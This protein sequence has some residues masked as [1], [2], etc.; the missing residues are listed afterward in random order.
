MNVAPLETSFSV[1]ADN[2]P[3]GLARPLVCRW[4]AQASTLGVVVFCHGLGSNGSEYAELSRHLAS[5]GYLMVHPTFDDAISLVAASEP[6]LGL[7]PTANLSHW[8]SLPEVRARMHQILLSPDSWLRRV[9]TVTAIMD[10]LPLVLSATCGSQ[11][12]PLPVA[13]AGHSF[14]AYTAQLLAGAEIDLPGDPG[15][16]FVDPRFAS[17]VFLSG[18]GRNQQGLRDGSWDRV[19]LPTLTITGTLDRGA[20]GGGWEWKSE[21]FTLASAPDQYLAVIEDGDHFLG[22]FDADHRRVV[23]AQ[24]AAVRQLTGQFLDSTLKQNSDSR[25]ALRATPGQIGDCRLTFHYR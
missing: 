7:D 16:R 19:A 21:P 15:R 4:P 5:R 14:G 9:A 17:A 10:A 20:N 6:S 24:A 1:L 12:K 23:A 18:Q 8:T 22:G 11:V 13:I 2:L 3:L 25:L